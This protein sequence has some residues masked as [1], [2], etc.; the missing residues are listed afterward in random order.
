MV[1]GEPRYVISIGKNI[2]ENAKDLSWSVSVE[3]KSRVEAEQLLDKAVK[4]LQGA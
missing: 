3:A 1:E 2:V 4:K